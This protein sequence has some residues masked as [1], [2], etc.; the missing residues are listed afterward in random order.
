M[1][2]TPQPTDPPRADAL[3]TVPIHGRPAPPAPH[4]TQ[5]LYPE[6]DATPLPESVEAPGGRYRLVRELARGGMGA[7]Y[8]GYDREL[9]RETAIKVL[10][11]RHLDEPDQVR[12]FYDEAWIAGQ[13]QHPGVVPVYDLGRLADGQPYFIMKLVEGRTLAELLRQRAAPNQDRPRLLKIFEQICQTM[14]YAHSRGVIHRDLKPSNVMVGEFGEVQVMDWGLARILAQTPGE[15]ASRPAGERRLQRDPSATLSWAGAVVGTPAYMAPEQARGEM[16]L[17]E[18]CDVFG[19]GAILYEI[20]TGRPPFAQTDPTEAFDRAAAGDLADAH[21]RLAACD[22]DPEL[23]VLARDCLDPVRDR[24]PRDAG[25]VS[26]RTSD[27]LARVQERMQQA[28]HDRAAAQL[29]A[30]EERK[31]RKLSVALA[32]LTFGIVLLA[33]VGAALHLN[34]RNHRERE[35]SAAAQAQAERRAAALARTHAALADAAGLREQAQAAGDD[36]LLRWTRALEAARRAEAALTDDVPDGDLRDHVAG[37]VNELTSAER[38]ARQTRR[39]RRMLDRLEEIRLSKTSVKDGRFDVSRAEPGYEAAFREYGIDLR[40]IGDA[41]AVEQIRSKP[42]MPELAAGLADWSALRLLGRGLDDALGLRLLAI[43]QAADPDPW[44]QSFR[45]ALRA[46]NAGELRHLAE[47]L[48]RESQP[49]AAVAV[50]ADVLRHFA[51]LPSA[52]RVYRLGVA[53]YPTDFWLNHNLGMALFDLAPLSDEALRFA[54]AAATLRPQSPGARLNLGVVLM[55]RGTWQAAADE[56]LAAVRLKDDYAEAHYSYGAALLQLGR[57]DDALREFRR[58]LELRPNF[59]QIKVDLAMALVAKG[60]WS[61]AAKVWEEV[62]KESPGQAILHYNLGNARAKLHRHR[63]AIAAYQRALA[64]DPLYAEAWCNLG[65]LLRDL[66]RF[67]EAVGKLT[68]GHEIGSR[69]PDWRYPSAAW[70][71]NA[72]ELRSRDAPL[73]AVLHG[74]PADV[75]ELL[76]LAAF[77]F[78]LKH[79]PVVALALIQRAAEQKPALRANW[80]WQLQRSVMTVDALRKLT[81]AGEFDEATRGRWR[82]GLLTV[83]R[84]DLVQCEKLSADLGAMFV[85][86]IEGRQRAAAFAPLRDDAALEEV[87]T[88]ERIAWAQYWTDAEALRRKLAT[89]K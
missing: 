71:S 87:S 19:L 48:E 25:E 27:Y 5:A 44:R 34:H 23:T 88:A 2:E 28:E 86:E 17:D 84:A 22:G 9:K 40:A 63:D 72:A 21:Q 89:A 10:L 12:R 66:G 33:G 38:A 29:R 1:A 15:A 62:I 69:R 54:A 8:R 81:E 80:V 47:R 57:A 58:A 36:A 16:D 77:A 76:R 59:P 74:Q 26:W 11:A 35:R 42:I 56:Y 50:L 75:A 61:E 73:Q 39:D 24:R 4:D 78:G 83:L 45:D 68:R 79:D 30:A 41:A 7:V 31:R 46:N 18:R 37:L 82:Q 60:D 65:L 53:R 49:A 14:A 43:A 67:D 3:V 32:A 55:R 70:L 6:T 51:D 20:L 64:L 13:L 85:R 52:V